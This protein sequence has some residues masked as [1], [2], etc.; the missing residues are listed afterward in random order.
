MESVPVSMFPS[1]VTDLVNLRYLAIQ[2]HDGSPQP[3]ISSLINLQT[4]IISSRN[5]ILLPKTIWD[6]INLSHLYIK[7]GEN[8]I[9]E[10]SSVQLKEDD[11]CHS[12]L[13]SLQTLT[14]VCP[15]FCVNLSSRI[16]NLK[17]LG[18]CGPLIST[19]G[20]IEFPNT[21]SLK[22]LQKLKLLNT[23]PYHEPTRSCDCRLFPKTLKKLTLSNIGLDW[24]Q[25]WTFVGLPNL[26]VL[27]LK[28]HVCI[29]KSGV[30]AMINILRD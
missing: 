22:H 9:D 23:I 11:G 3:S 17:K 16:P 18:F 2:A 13:A 26:E 15:Q 27:K 8:L 29:E 7:S 28:S 12:G 20:D 1:D 6:I 21:Q 25:I 4:L 14:Q 10:L 5:N 19:Q 30:R 24:A